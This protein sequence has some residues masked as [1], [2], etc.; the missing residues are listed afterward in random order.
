MPPLPK[1]GIKSERD[2]ISLPGVR[3][4]GEKDVFAG[5]NP[6]AYAFRRL[7]YSSNIYRVRLQ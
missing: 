2:L 6:S 5:P 1:Q 7:A 4:I 3:V